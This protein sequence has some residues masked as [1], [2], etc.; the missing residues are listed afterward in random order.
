[1]ALSL[2]PKHL[3]YCLITLKVDTD[4]MFLIKKLSNQLFANYSFPINTNLNQ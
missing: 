2:I 3:K 1:M 4:T